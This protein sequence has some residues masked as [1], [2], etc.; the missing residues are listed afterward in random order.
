E[1]L[2]ARRQRRRRRVEQFLPVG[3]AGEKFAVPPHGAGVDR[4]ALGVGDRRQHATGPTEDGPG[5]IVPAEFSD[6]HV[7]PFAWFGNAATGRKF[8]PAV[9]TEPGLGH[10]HASRTAA[11]SISRAPAAAASPSV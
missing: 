8:P 9:S 3:I 5:Q 2:F 7:A 6:T 4:L 11:A 10:S 1:R